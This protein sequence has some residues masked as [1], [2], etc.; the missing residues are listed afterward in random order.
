MIANFCN[1]IH[2]AQADFL[3]IGLLL[4]CRETFDHA[5]HV[6]PKKSTFWNQKAAEGQ[7][8]FAAINEPARTAT[9]AEQKAYAF[10]ALRNQNEWWRTR[11]NSQWCRKRAPHY[12]NIHLSLLVDSCAILKKA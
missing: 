1:A 6:S 10:K 3:L 8:V 7:Q 9:C 12:G 11:G 4:Q 2:F 5:R